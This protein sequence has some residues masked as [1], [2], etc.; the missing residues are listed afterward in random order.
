MEPEYFAN[1]GYQFWIT[2]R[3]GTP[4]LIAAGFRGQWV[5]VLPELSAVG[6]IKSESANPRAPIRE[7]LHLLPQFVLPA[8]GELSSRLVSLATW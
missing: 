4:A 3:F 6:V 7:Y 8:M 1:Y 2:E 5:I